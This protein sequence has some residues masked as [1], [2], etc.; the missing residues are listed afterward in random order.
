MFGIKLWYTPGPRGCHRCGKKGVKLASP[1]FGYM[2][3]WCADCL[4]ETGRLR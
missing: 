4:L 1:G 3:L 2:Q